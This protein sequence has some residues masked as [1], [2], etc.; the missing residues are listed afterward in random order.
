M[1]QFSGC[2]FAPDEGSQDF[3]RFISIPNDGV[4]PVAITFFFK[5]E[6]KKENIFRRKQ[7]NLGKVFFGKKK[8]EYVTKFEK[9]SRV[10]KFEKHSRVTK[11]EKHSR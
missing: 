3:T 11:L 4:V 9:H 10:T 2:I 5:C 6:S 1:E 7:K 8:T